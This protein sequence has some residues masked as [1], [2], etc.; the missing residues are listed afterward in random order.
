MHPFMFVLK[1]ATLKKMPD[2]KTVLR[3]AAAD[4]RV[5]LFEGFQMA[6]DK[7]RVYNVKSAPL[8]EIDDSLTQEEIMEPGTYTWDMF[9]ALIGLLEKGELDDTTK[10]KLMYEACEESGIMEWNAFYRPII[11]K[12]LKCGVT[13][14]TINVILD[15]FGADARKYKT[16]IWKIQKISQSGLRAGKKF[17]EPLLG[18]KRAITVI[19]KDI[20]TVRMYSETGTLMKNPKI[21][22]EPLLELSYQFPGS[23]VFDGNIINRDYGA[24]MNKDGKKYHYAI[25]DILPLD[26]FNQSYCPM[27]LEDRKAALNDLNDILREET[28]GQVYVLPSLFFDFAAENKEKRLQEF[29]DEISNAGFDYIVVKDRQSHY[30]CER[31]LSWFKLPNE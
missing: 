1:L 5:Q 4:G 26:D 14:K 27:P 25:Y 11:M 15:E 28:N 3:G 24:L 9:K 16:P 17:L 21:D 7:K 31:D 10:K 13:A 20:R 6:F 2:K 12:N 29:K 19:N 18:G 8:I 30:T 23:I 22:L